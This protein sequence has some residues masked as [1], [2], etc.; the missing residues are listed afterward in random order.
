MI[1]LCAVID[2]V[3]MFEDKTKNRRHVRLVLLRMYL[4]LLLLRVIIRIMR[5]AW[6]RRNSYFLEKFQG[7]VIFEPKIYIANFPTYW[8]LFLAMK[9]RHKFAMLFQ[10]RLV[11]GGVGGKGR[12]KLFQT[13]SLTIIVIQL[14]LYFY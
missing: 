6:L 10:N 12:L 11:G 1:Y 2:R 4:E 5:E 7:G 3:I 9:R 13:K 8:D 14:I